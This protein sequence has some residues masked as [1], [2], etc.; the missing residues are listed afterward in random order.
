MK[1]FLISILLIAFVAA[2]TPTPPD[3]PMAGSC[4]VVIT[5]WEYQGNMVNFS[6]FFDIEA[7]KVRFEGRRINTVVYDPF[8]Y[9]TIQDLITNTE[10]Y[11]IKEDSLI[12]Q[13]IHRLL[14]NKT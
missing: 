7:E 6:Y 11:I 3:L 2:Q 13:C 14:V 1:A 12:S 5:N 10:Y 4:T 8:Y 9:I